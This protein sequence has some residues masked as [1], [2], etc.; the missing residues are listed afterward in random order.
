MGAPA[1]VR[2]DRYSRPVARPGPRVGAG[3][4]GAVLRRAV[5]QRYR[6]RHPARQPAAHHVRGGRGAGGHFQPATG[7]V[8]RRRF[9]PRTLPPGDRGDPAAHGGGRGGWRPGPPP[10]SRPGRATLLGGGGGAGERFRRTLR[11]PECRRS[12]IHA[13]H[14]TGAPPA[15]GAPA[16]RIGAL[17]QLCAALRGAAVGAGLHRPLRPLPGDPDGRPA[18]PERRPARR[19]HSPWHRGRR[20]TGGGG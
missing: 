17:V 8:V 10:A 19:P 1:P 9:Q 13:A 2:T 20:A 7:A 3:R 12:G 6:R 5:R 4:A 15:G 18:V 14:R 16:Q 11:A